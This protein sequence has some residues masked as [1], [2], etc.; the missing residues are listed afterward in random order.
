MP[1]LPEVETQV[2]DLQEIV[3]K[4]ILV[5]SSNTKKAFTPVFAKFKKEIENKKML[6]VSRKTDLLTG[7]HDNNN[8]NKINK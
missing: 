2:R 5:L 6:T 3:E 8:R 7:W 1:E 4:R